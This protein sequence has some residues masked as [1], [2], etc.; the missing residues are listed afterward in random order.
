MTNALKLAIFN[1][2]MEEEMLNKEDLLYK[3]LVDGVADK[4]AQKHAA[5]WIERLYLEI[6][7]LK[8]TK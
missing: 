5:D 7:K 3:M 8:K 1:H 4:E 6:D 2:Q